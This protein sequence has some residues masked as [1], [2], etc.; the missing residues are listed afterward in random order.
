MYMCN[1]IDSIIISI[2]RILLKE[3]MR[4]LIVSCH[5]IPATLTQD[6]GKFINSNIASK[7]RNTVLFLE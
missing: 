2:Y 3:D 6:F 7:N 5:S 1:V 4:V